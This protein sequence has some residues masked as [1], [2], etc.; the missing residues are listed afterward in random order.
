VKE[1][2]EEKIALYIFSLLPL[3]QYLDAVIVDTPI[4]DEHV[5]GRLGTAYQIQERLARTETFLGYLDQCSKAVRD[6]ELLGEWRRVTTLARQDIS[7][8]R[9]RT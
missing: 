5:R 2:A 8:I 1:P 3:F 6:G 4:L 7:E 9:R